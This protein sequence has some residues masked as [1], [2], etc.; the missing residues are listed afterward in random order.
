MQFAEDVT[1]ATMN[2]MSMKDTA[3]A[4]GFGR[5][6]LMSI[7]RD[8]KILMK[9]N[10]PYQNFIDQGYFTVR[11]SVGNGYISN[12]TFVT[13]KGEIWLHKF[14]TKNEYL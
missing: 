7:L 11:Q 2:V 4:L 8:E 6:T 3:K 12:T 14:L 5:N 13:G 10:T 1:K 9:N